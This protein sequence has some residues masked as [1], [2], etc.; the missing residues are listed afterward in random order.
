MPWYLFSSKGV[1]L[2]DGSVLRN[3]IW[4]T[5][6]SERYLWI[7][8][9]LIYRI[10]IFLFNNAYRNHRNVNFLNTI[11]CHWI[12]VHIK[13]SICMNL[14]RKNFPEIWRIISKEVEIIIFKVIFG[15]Y[16]NLSFK[17]IC[18]SNWPSFNSFHFRLA[19]YVKIA[20]ENIWA[21]LHYPSDSE[22]QIFISR[23]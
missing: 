23:D 15:N 11:C 5:W 8:L 12:Y 4:G 7:L 1:V 21:Y 20:K 22:K 19:Y 6:K 17:L 9:L 13:L 14:C 10:L 2:R 16:C 3:K 18:P